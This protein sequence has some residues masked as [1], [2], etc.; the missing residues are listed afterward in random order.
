MIVNINGENYTL[1]TNS[2]GQVKVSTASLTPGNYEVI[3]SYAGNTKYNPTN[4]IASVVVYKAATSISAIDN[5]EELVATLTNEYAKTLV[6]ANVVVNIN[7]VDYS[8]KTNSKGQVKVSTSGLDPKVYTATIS[9][10]GN[11]KYNSASTTI[12]AAEGKTM[13]GLSTVYDDE[14]GEV[15]TTLIN[16]VT[17]NVIKG[18]KVTINIYGVKTSQFT[19]SNGQVRVSS[20][21][22]TPNAYVVTSSYAGNS[23]YTATSTIGSIFITN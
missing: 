5:G 16:T 17:G 8:L 9:Y 20:E 13:T 10:A 19:D 3:I 22:L 4:A 2:N 18:A 7:G 23:K 11:A 6:S 14:T 21:G 15:V 12:K 1:K